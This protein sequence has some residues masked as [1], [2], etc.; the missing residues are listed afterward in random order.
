MYYEHDVIVK[1]QI[2]TLTDEVTP[3]NV[4][5]TFDNGFWDYEVE[6]TQLITP[7]EVVSKLIA[8]I[9]H[10]GIEKYKYALGERADL[11]AEVLDELK[12]RME[13]FQSIYEEAL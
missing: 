8:E 10:C 5:E 12:S 2:N 11:V 9:K 3:A 7:V 6:N 13:D 1:M 4:K